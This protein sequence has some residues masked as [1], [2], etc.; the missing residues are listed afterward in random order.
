M[1]IPLE[2]RAHFYTGT[3]PV[4]A[5]CEASSP[6]DWKSGLFCV[7]AFRTRGCTPCA[8]LLLSLRTLRLA[9]FADANSITH[10]VLNM[11]P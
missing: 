9:Q 7:T 10:K 3:S 11:S 1:K 4:Y 5:L 6:D 2:Q 8:A